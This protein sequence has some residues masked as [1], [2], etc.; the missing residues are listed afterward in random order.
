MIRGLYRRP[1]FIIV[2]AATLYAA[3]LALSWWQGTEKAE[4]RMRTMLEAAETG[5][6]NVINGEIEAALRNVG[7]AIINL[8][9]GRC[10]ALPPERMVDLAKTF[11]LDEINIVGRDGI[12][13]ASNLKEVLGYDFK[14][15]PLTAEFLALTNNTVTLISQP[16]RA[17]VANPEMYCKY[18]GLAFP[19]RDG[20]LQLGM[21]GER[22]RQNMYTYS[23]KEADL[24]LKEWHFSVVGWYERATNDPQ[25]K[26]GRMFRQW[27]RER[28]EQVVG[29]YF[30]YQ[31]YQYVAFLPESYCYSQRN[32]NFVITALVLTV[33]ITIFTFVLIMLAKTSG[34]L[35][36]MHL[37]AAQRAAADL[38]IA[39]TIQMSAIPSSEGAF[40]DHLEFAFSA[41][42]VPAREVGGDFY[43]FYPVAG[44]RLVFL[45]A[46]VSGKGISGAMFM[47]EAKNV[48]KNC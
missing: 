16:F 26:P 18:Y 20:I 42:T 35:E 41:V 23:A 19:G 48:I 15:H 3:M 36:K 32:A 34:K 28:N 11:N 39:K 31:G 46:D 40:M 17:G 29:R 47:M 30:D 10:V 38:S 24:I 45:V 22:L 33:L 8:L 7:G 9:G 6:A 21:S 14:K 37:A 2:V 25:F 12:T 43:D 1:K 5:Y 44:G 4:K 27:N 13:I